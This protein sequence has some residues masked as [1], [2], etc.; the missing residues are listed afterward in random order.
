MLDINF[1]R[2]DLAGVITRL[3]ARKTPQAFL[4]VD[5]FTQLETERKTIQMRTEELQAKRNALSKQIGQLK[6]KG[7]AGQENGL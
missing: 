6:A 2:K 5:A 3:E 1:L 7:A 4:N